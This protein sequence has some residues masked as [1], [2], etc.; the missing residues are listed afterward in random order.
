M[1]EGLGRIVRGQGGGWGGGLGFL[2]AESLYTRRP[3]LKQACGQLV[4]MGWGTKSEQSWNQDSVI[5]LPTQGPA[6]SPS[7]GGSSWEA[8]EKQKVSG[9]PYIG[10]WFPIPPCEVRIL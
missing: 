6:F 1:G 5:Y 3:G 8:T 7:L 2:R 4:A 9:H 10:S